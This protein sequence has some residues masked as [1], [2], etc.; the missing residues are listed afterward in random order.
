MY[1]F[2]LLENDINEATSYYVDIIRKALEKQGEEVVYTSSLN[3]IS[4]TDKVLTIQA[5]AFFYVWL[6]NRKQ[7]IVNWYQGIVPEEA[8]CLFENSSS[9]YVRKYVW[10]F[11]EKLSLKYAAKTIFVSK[12]MLVHYQ[13]KYGYDKNNYFI[14]PCFNQELVQDSFRNSKYQRPSFVYA[15]SLSRWQCIEKTLEIFKQ[16]KEVIPQ[17]TLTLLTKEKDKAKYLCEKYGINAEIKF[18]PSVQLQKTLQQYKYGF[19]VRDNIPVNNIAT[20]TKMNSY[21]A[22][23]V[24]PIY[25]DVIHDFN[26]VFS[27]LKYVISFSTV[28]DCISRIVEMEANKI[29]LKAILEEYNSIFQ[30][31][32]STNKYI[33]LIGPFLNESC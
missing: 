1:K 15:G 16:I 12:A 7:Y 27:H 11:W 23:G 17:S 14:M 21:M 28:E 32:Y 33:D 22:A 26:S 6:R 8:M 13:N 10:T 30:S 31:Y 2:Y 5:K 24:I 25:S 29:E 19:I 3:N 20:P 4:F 9:K 18:V